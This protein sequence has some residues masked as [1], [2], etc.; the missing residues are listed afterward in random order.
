MEQEQQ[1]LEELRRSRYRARTAERSSLVLNNGSS[2]WA[3]NISVSAL[4]TGLN[5]GK[6]VLKKVSLVVAD[7]P[8]G[9]TKEPW[10]FEPSKVSLCVDAFYVC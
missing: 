5:I 6:E 8:Y 2:H 10:D 4:S 7:I 9:L 1:R 3:S